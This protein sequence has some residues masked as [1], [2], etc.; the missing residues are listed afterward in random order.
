MFIFSNL[1]IAVAKIVDVILTV[2]YWLILI[3]VL[4]SWVNP[5]PYNAIV[6]FLYRM[7]DPVLQ[8]I[9]KVLPPMGIDISPILAFLAIIFLR[10]FL[11]TTLMD[12]GLRLR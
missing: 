12:I 5:D 8:R 7:T 1:F 9:R 6:Q 10:A 3:R 2:Y 11:V 4:I